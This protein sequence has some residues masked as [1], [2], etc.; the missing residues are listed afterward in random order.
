MLVS[1]EQISAT[2]ESA[3]PPEATPESWVAVNDPLNN[4]KWMLQSL[5][6]R[7][8]LEGTAITLE[9]SKNAVHGKAGCNEYF[10]G[11]ELQA[12]YVASESGNLEIN[13]VRTLLHCSSP[14]G[15]MEQEEAYFEALSRVAGFELMEN[16]LELK[17]GSGEIKLV[18][19][20]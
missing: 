14:E 15:V 8:L 4:T 12:T 16:R 3:E 6:G 2:T 5:E 19:T 10:G 9:F 20:K 17:D 13:F 18:F 7:S 1:C 11:E